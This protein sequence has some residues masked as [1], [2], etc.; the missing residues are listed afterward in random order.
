MSKSK[1]FNYKSTSRKSYKSCN[2]NTRIAICPP[3]VFNANIQ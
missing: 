3:M 2:E 1:F